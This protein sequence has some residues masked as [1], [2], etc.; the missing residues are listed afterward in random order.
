MF[1]IFRQWKIAFFL[2]LTN[3][4]VADE[5]RY[6][7]TWVEGDAVSFHTAPLSLGN[8]LSSGQRMA[9]NGF[10]LIDA[11]TGMRNG[12]R[13]YAGLWTKGSGSTIFEGPFGPIDL[14][15]ALIRR[16]AQGMIATDFEIFRRPNGGRLYTVVFRPGTSEQRISRPMLRDA[17]LARGEA[18][19]NENLHLQDVEVEDIDGELF[20]S[21]LFRAG[22]GL[23]AFTTPVS[24]GAFR[25]SLDDRLAQGLELVDMERVPGTQKVIGVFRSGDSPAEITSPR[26][27]GQHF[28]LAGQQLSAGMRTRDFEFVPVESPPGTGGGGGTVDPGNPPPMP[29]NPSHVS[30][31]DTLTLR[32][33]FTQ[34]DDELFQIELPLSALPDW[35]PQTED[36]TPVLPDDYC[37]LLLIEADSISWQVG[38][39]SPFTNQVFNSVPSVPALGSD[40]FLGGVQFSGPMGGCTGTQKKWSFPHPFTTDPVFTPLPNMS[41]VVELRQGSEI[42]FIKDTGP[43]PK[44]IDVDKLFKDDS[45][46]KLKDQI[47]FWNALMKQ[48]DNIDKYCGS[49][50]KYWDVLC[51]QF[52]D[53][54]AICGEEV[55]ELP[56]C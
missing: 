28:L 22:A 16:R 8:F 40:L 19:L 38:G 13:L 34:I 2:L 29:Q 20:Y 30:F 53:N 41:L 10:V 54:D 42:A 17:F 46:K 39:V 37:G 49:V 6:E 9:Q 47:K 27:F 33:Q 43:S 44:K 3:L 1:Y 23:N 14:R 36:G 18:M 45:Q 7:A 4:A 11:E 24:L 26:S 12:Q 15:E 52:P 50:G 25:A 55:V 51:T 56:G 5:L 32:I 21:G 48:Q 35:L 31:T